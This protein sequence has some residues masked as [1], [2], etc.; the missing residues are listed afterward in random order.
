MSIFKPTL[1]LAGKIERTESAAM[2]DSDQIVKGYEYAKGTFAGLN[3][4][5]GNF[6]GRTHFAGSWLRP[7]TG[8]LALNIPRSTNNS[9]PQLPTDLATDL[10]INPSLAG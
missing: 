5:T 2:V 3:L 4:S 10:T 9:V 8:G 1:G 6:A 7:S